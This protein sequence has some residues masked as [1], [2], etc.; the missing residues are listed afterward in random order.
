[1]QHDAAILGTG[2]S[3]SLLGWILAE[4]GWRVVLI[5][6]DEHP[7][8]AIGESSTPL[9]DLLIEKLADEYGL[10]ELRPLSRWGSWQ[11]Q[12]PHIRGGK[13]RGFS[14]FEH[15]PGE[16]F[17]DTPDHRHSLLVAASPDDERSD[18]HWLR[19]DV[20]A[21]F[22]LHAC[23]AGCTG[24]L[25][26]EVLN[27]R[28]AASG[29][30]V[31]YRPIGGE[32]DTFQCREV[33]DA[34]GS[35]EVLVK[36]L[37]LNDFTDR[38]R[39]RTG[40]LFGHFRGIGSMEQWMRDR[41]LPL[42]PLVFPPDESAQHHLLQSGWMWMLR[43]V[44]GTTSVGIVQT[45]DNWRPF[46]ALDCK[47]A[48][49]DAW[50]LFLARYPTLYDLMREAE[51][52]APTVAGTPQLAWMPRIGRRVGPAAGKG[53]CLLPSTAGIIDPLH[54]TGIA[55]A[56]SGVR[57]V[58]SFLTGGSLAQR[59][60]YSRAVDAELDWIDRLVSA[61]YAAMPY[62]LPLFAAATSFYLVAAIQ[63]ERSLQATGTLTS[64]F[65]QWED[66]ALQQQLEW[67]AQR[68]AAL[69][70][71]AEVPGREV[72]ALI[73]EVR[74]RLAPWNDVGLLD[75]TLGNRIARTA[76]DK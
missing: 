70:A 39:T 63:S 54:S 18:T 23:Q 25:N 32:V 53:W 21:W 52:V 57:R 6:R 16:P 28:R 51:L 4:C 67:F 24:F 41:G 47:G 31:V 11:Q 5:D 34:T 29:W 73:D 56:L 17:S 37:G 14:Y 71:P 49:Q 8:F 20:D 7:R 48:R 61:A 76:A 38:L 42:E 2:F 46:G 44:D 13:K 35:E 75:P 62:G 74:Q 22:Y 72:E 45:Q 26:T 50:Q 15:R 65:L 27:V 1:M 60:E 19:A 33:I 59:A 68:V 3:G 40:A 10:K 64:G 43:F 12:I 55:H 66:Q 9:A 30:D 36:F 69:P 58:A